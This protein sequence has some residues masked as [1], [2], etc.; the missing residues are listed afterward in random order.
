[1]KR[2]APN[3]RPRAV[4]EVIKRRIQ[5]NGEAPT[6]AE[7]CA[8]LGYRSPATVH[9]VLAQLED[10]QLIT[11]IPN[12]SRGIRLSEPSGISIDGFDTDVDDFEPDFTAL[13]RAKPK[14]APQTPFVDPDIARQFKAYEKDWQERMSGLLAIQK[15]YM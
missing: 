5:S 12:V 3:T 7:I 13:D 10:E 15:E 14:T 8:E 1:M 2:R 4:Y 6:I 9:R 11:R